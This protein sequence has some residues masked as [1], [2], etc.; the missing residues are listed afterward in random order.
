MD[1]VKGSVFVFL[2]KT[3][4]KSKDPRLFAYLTDDDKQLLSGQVYPL[5]WYPIDTFWRC[6][7]ACYEVLGERTPMNARNWGRSFTV[8]VLESFYQDTLVM[9]RRED[10][11]LVFKNILLIFKRL[12]SNFQ[13]VLSSSED[14]KIQLQLTRTGNEPDAKILYFILCGSFEKCTEMAGGKNARAYFSEAASGNKM[15]VNFYL[16]WE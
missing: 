3:I 4:R 1:K 11:A 2:A 13:L 16:R 10:I 14:K 7:K 15:I 8:L 9:F 5:V 12:F 6:L